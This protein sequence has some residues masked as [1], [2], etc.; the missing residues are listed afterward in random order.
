MDKIINMC[1]LW[2]ILFIVLYNNE[3]YLGEVFISLKLFVMNNLFFE[4]NLMK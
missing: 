1:N 4:Y 3:Y 2:N